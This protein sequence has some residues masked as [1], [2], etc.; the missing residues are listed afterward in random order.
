MHDWDVYE[1]NCLDAEE[2][3]S[4]SQQL[5]PDSYNS[6]IYNVIRTW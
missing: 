6:C 2:T 4:C 1:M 3:S 5:P